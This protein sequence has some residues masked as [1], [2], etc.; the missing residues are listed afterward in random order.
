MDFSQLAGSITGFIQS[1]MP[2][3]GAVLALACLVLG[4]GMTALPEEYSQKA[5]KIMIAMVIGALI[6]FSAT[7]ISAAIK[8][9]LGF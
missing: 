3:V 1:F 2:V 9:G 7:G 5:K 8:S 6:C 4:L